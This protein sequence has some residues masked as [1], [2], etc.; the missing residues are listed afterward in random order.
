MSEVLLSNSVLV[1]LLSESIL[2]IMLS[3]AFLVSVRVLLKWDF[4]SFTPS[5]FKL[6]QESYLV[7]TI[8]FFI[9]IMKFLLIIYFAFTVDNLSVLVAGAMCGAGVIQ[10]N[11]YG[12]YLLTLKLSILFGLTLW[13][14]L[15]HYDLQSKN[16][17]WFKEK[18]ALFIALFLFMVLEIY[19]DFSYFINIDTHQAVSCCSA[20]F[21]QL[22][23]AN[24]LPFGLN[25]T[26]LLSLF[27]LLFFMVIVTLILNQSWLYILSNLLFLYIA[28]YALIYFFGTY[29]YQ[30]PTHKCPFCMLQK[31]YYYVGYA[32][33]FSLFIGSSI[34]INGAIANLWLKKDTSIKSKKM[35]IGL[36]SFFVLL[37]S[38]YVLIYYFRNGVWL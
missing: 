32:L 22:E 37:C 19:L 34:G 28:Y 31:E 25:I 21:G 6:E 18:S 23:G 11:S 9:F 3:V 15:N 29:I 12:D 4:N 1:Y 2:F 7:T 14:Y 13:F 8:A 20:L 24:P 26:T 33:W 27:Y 35:V 30:L 36:L 38:A 17:Q 10:A 16:Y 5:Q